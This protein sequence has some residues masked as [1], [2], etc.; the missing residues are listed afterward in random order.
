MARHVTGP[1]SRWQGL[2]LIYFQRQVVRIAKEG[3]AFAGK[4]IDAN[5]FALDAM[6]RQMRYRGV[7]IIHAKGQMT[8]PAG[9][10][11][12]GAGRETGTRTAQSRTRH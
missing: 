12:T 6:R 5:R 4:G 1:G 3:K 10:G 7:D 2:L 11:A 8:Q 9:F